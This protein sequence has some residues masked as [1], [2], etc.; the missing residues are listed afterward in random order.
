MYSYEKAKSCKLSRSKREPRKPV[1]IQQIV[2][3]VRHPIGSKQ[4]IKWRALDVH[5]VRCKGGGKDGSWVMQ[6]EMQ[7]GVAIDDA[8]KYK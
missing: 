7:C 2:C 4:G 8:E 3:C 6:V 1:V 5:A